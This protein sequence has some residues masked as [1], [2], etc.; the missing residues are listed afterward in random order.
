MREGR[1]RPRALAGGWCRRCRCRPASAIAAA[2][3]RRPR[4]AATAGRARPRARTRRSAPRCSSCSL[5]AP[6]RPALARARRGRGTLSLGTWFASGELGIALSRSPSMRLSLPVAALVALIALVDAALLAELP[7]P[8]G[9]L[10][11]LLPRHE[12]VFAAGMLLIVLAGNAGAGLRRLGAGRHQLLAAD[13]LR[14]RA[15]G[16]HRQRA[17]APSS[18]TASAMPASSSPSR[19]PS[20]WLGTRRVA[21]ALRPRRSCR[22]RRGCWRS[23]FVVAGGGQVGATAVHALDRPRAWKGRRP[24]PPSSTARSWSMPGCCCCCAW[25]RCCA[26][27]PDVH[28]PAGGAG[29]GRPRSDGSPRAGWSRPTSRPR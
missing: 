21:G 20:C 22:S 14:L 2:R 1:L 6:G 26:Q 25:S 8:G 16:G 23:A 13:R 12:P 11:P 19:C 9:G 5:L 29:P 18:P 17:A 10:P 4:P 15:A 7:A 27:A 3:A 28:G 24:R